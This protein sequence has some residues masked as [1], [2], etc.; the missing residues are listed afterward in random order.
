MCA[1]LNTTD[2]TVTLHFE[3]CMDHSVNIHTCGYLNV[4]EASLPTSLKPLEAEI[5]HIYSIVIKNSRH[6]PRA[7]LRT[8]LFGTTHFQNIIN[9]K[10][11][12]LLNFSICRTRKCVNWT[13]FR[14]QDCFLLYSY[15]TLYHFIHNTVTLQSFFQ[16]Q[17]RKK[18]K[19]NKYFGHII[20]RPSQA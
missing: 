2:E 20:E 12:G 7:G 9:D 15:K 5:I 17:I 13:V 18:S 1:S 10:I 6:R 19:F 8:G 14:G 11:N 3:A 16:L 4:L